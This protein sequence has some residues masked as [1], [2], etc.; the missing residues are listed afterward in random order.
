MLLALSFFVG[1]FLVG[2]QIGLNAIA[3]TMYPTDIRSTGVGWALGVGRI[4]SIL[5]PILG[6][7][8]ISRHIPLQSVFIYT[9]LVVLACA[10]AI[11]YTSYLCYAGQ[12]FRLPG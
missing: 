3:G 12:I 1:F 5:G 11:F 4:G 9:S 7:I 8:L 2:G 6:G 10:I